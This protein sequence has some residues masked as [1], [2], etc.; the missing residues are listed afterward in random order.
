[1]KKEE[2]PQDEGSLSKS[3]MKELVYATDENGKYTTALSKGWEP[4]TIA[5]SMSIKDLTDRIIAANK[6]VKDG[7]VSPIFY[8]MELN[9][10]DLAI[11][12]SYAG[13]WKWRVKRHFKPKVFAG[14]SDKILLKYAKAFNISI[15]ELKNVKIFDGH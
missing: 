11:L 14:L 8:Y 10:M 9:R 7:E 15:E 3:K 12:S 1:M 6:Q 5:L 2:V 4:K 13:L